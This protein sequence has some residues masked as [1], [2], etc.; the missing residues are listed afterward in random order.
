MLNDRG[1]R[2][3]N[4]ESR[5]FLYLL[6][7]NSHLASSQLH[8]YRL[9]HLHCIA[10]KWSYR[11]YVNSFSERRIVA[12]PNSIV[13]MS[14]S[15]TYIWWNEYSTFFIW[16]L[17]IKKKKNKFWFLIISPEQQNPFAEPGPYTI[18]ERIGLKI[19]LKR[20]KT[21]ANDE[22]NTNDGKKKKK[23]TSS[24]NQNV[25]VRCGC[26]FWCV[27]VDRREMSN[28]S[29]CA[30]QLLLFFCICFFVLHFGT[31]KRNPHVNRPT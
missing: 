15:Q 6:G 14:L 13:H 3:R 7:T 2:M 19:H 23:K 17:E 4:I 20:N 26:Y 1:G 16:I 28:K 5:S 21:T 12:L 31:A 18:Q 11:I 8:S 30:T 9:L 22:T 24:K 29:F 25:W 10:N 27:V